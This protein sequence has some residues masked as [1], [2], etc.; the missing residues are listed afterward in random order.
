MYTHTR[1]EK[2]RAKFKGWWFAEHPNLQVLLVTGGYNGQRLSST[3]VSF[4]CGNRHVSAKLTNDKFQ[5][6][7]PKFW[8]YW[9]Q[10]PR[11]EA[12]SMSIAR[13]LFP[14]LEV[15]TPSPLD[16]PNG[17]FTSTYFFG[18]SV[19]ASGNSWKYPC[20]ISIP[21]N[22]ENYFLFLFPVWRKKNTIFALCFM[23]NWH[24]IF[25]SLS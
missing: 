6:L 14:C 7:P 9:D 24:A 18:N 19:L 23:K 16:V 17:I 2:S 10:I 22:W 8:E 11:G 1:S 21:K 12:P 4:E 15:S 5:F 13:Y 3:E 20:L 25:H